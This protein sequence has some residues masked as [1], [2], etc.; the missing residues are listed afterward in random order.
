MGEASKV[1]L[2]L[3]Q[4][5]EWAKQVPAVVAELRARGCDI[6]A[7][8][9]EDGAAGAVNAIGE[10]A[11]KRRKFE[12]DFERR[13]EDPATSV[14]THGSYSDRRYRLAIVSQTGAT[15]W[16]AS[17]P[18]DTGDRYSIRTGRLIGGASYSSPRFIS[19]GSTTNAD[20]LAARRKYDA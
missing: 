7:C 17:H 19:W 3:Y 2:S 15:V 4:L 1:S 6:A 8:E 13:K 10:M 11:E 20:L 12:E 5:T 9:L 16:L 14:E 18:D